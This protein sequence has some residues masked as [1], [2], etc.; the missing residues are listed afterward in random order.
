MKYR[1][2]E[3]NRYRSHFMRAT[4]QLMDKLLV[5]EFCFYLKTNAE[6]EDY[7]FIRVD[8]K[9]VRVSVYDLQEEGSTLH[10]SFA[11]TEDGRVFFL[12]SLNYRAEL[13]DREKKSASKANEK[14]CTIGKMGCTRRI[15]FMFK[16]MKCMKG[17][18]DKADV[19]EEYDFLLIKHNGNI[20]QAQ[21][22]MLNNIQDWLRWNFSET[23]PQCVIWDR[24][25]KEN[26]I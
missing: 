25:H 2:E 20:E 6:F 16:V 21:K 9:Q 8:G 15:E 24:L 12:V 5:D 7:D 26:L 22:E 14:C 1:R 18:A 23:D 4:E 13:V 10:K 19:K 17:Y 11:V 3:D